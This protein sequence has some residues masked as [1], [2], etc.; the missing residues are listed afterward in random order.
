MPGGLTRRACQH[1]A[2]QSLKYPAGTRLVFICVPLWLVYVTPKPEREH[3]VNIG[4]PLKLFTAPS[5]ET[6]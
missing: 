3:S 4:N 1:H 6:D 2:R 5:T